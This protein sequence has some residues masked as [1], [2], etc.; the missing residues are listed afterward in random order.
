MIRQLSFLDAIRVTNLT[1]RDWAIRSTDLATGGAS[2][3]AA[4]LFLWY[5]ARA[6]K[7][8]V[9]WICTE[10]RRAVG[11]IAANPCSG[12]SAWMVEHLVT[13]HTYENLWSKLLEKTVIHAGLH[14]G[15]RLFLS[16]PQ[17]WRILN[18]AYNCGF[19]P[20]TQ[21][22][23]LTLPGRSPLL[24]I[25][26]LLGFRRRIPGDDYLL[27]RLYNA[28]IPATVRHNIGMTFQQWRD[29]QT[30]LQGGTQEWVLEDSQGINLCVR[31]DRHKHGTKVRLV[32]HPVWA[33]DLQALVSFVLAKNRSKRIWWEVSDYQRALQSLL[34][35]LGFEVT[36]AYHIVVKPLAAKVAE[37]ALGPVLVS[38]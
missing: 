16:I 6:P 4:G 28:A 38:S 37:P 19:V 30:P 23:V 1:G 25:A 21:L 5:C 2:S 9:A 10:G 33:G 18:I 36:G 14:G 35:R 3:F 7:R 11:L 34:E 17:E 26:P 24:A 29:A 15:D 12:P 22:M 27:F 8:S 32:I 20:F 31:L 13:H